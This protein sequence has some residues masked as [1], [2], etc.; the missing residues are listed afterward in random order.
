M[1]KPLPIIKPRIWPKLQLN[2]FYGG[3][4]TRDA[5]SDIADNE[6]QDLLNVDFAN[7]GGVLKRSGTNIV[8]NDKGNTKVLGLH[9]AYYG[10]GSA[11]LLMAN[12]DASTSGLWYRTTGNYTEV[13][14]DAGGTK[15]A[16]ADCEFASFYDNTNEVVFVADGTTFQKYRPSSN[17]LY[18]A[19]E[20]PGTSADNVTI[21]K[22]YKNR[23]YATGSSTNPERVY[24]SA[25]GD[26]DNFSATDYF[27]VPS[28]SVTQS[29]KTG[30]PIMA[31]TVLQNR[32]I[33]FKARSVWSYDTR[34][35][36]QLSGAHGCVGK[37]AVAVSDYFAFFA[38]NDGVY[39]LSGTSTIKVSKKIQPTWD[40]IPA[41]RIP[42]I[43]M[44]VFKG[45]LYVATAAAGAT[46][47]DII[48][49]NY[50]ELPP[51]QDGQQAW[52]YWNGLNSDLAAAAFT[53]YEASTTTIPILIFGH[54]GAQGATLQLG[55]GNADYEFTGPAQDE[56][57]D[58][59]YKTKDFPISARF[60]RLFLALGTTAAT[61]NLNVSAVI[62]FETTRHFTAGMYHATATAVTKKGYINYS[63]KYI[64]YKFATSASSAQP[65]TI[66]EGKQEFKPIR[67]R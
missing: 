2:N 58:G 45:K 60:K 34:A 1:P 5:S 65:F 44:E 38:D 26:G 36:R 17:T 48:L 43:A 32:L 7:A 61:N 3:L 27:D 6:S 59:Y 47:N 24:Y 52:S 13:T 41:A 51:D 15:L 40:V 62:D 11:H 23:L 53:V 29:G 8:G 66:Y 28:Q 35:L 9:S 19:D 18:N 12:Q 50:L 14:K 55:T 25:L 64:N 56:S 46:T 31:L 57:I 4:N 49:V 63:G 37:R 39:R 30:D 22:V 21:L 20:I 67:L 10:N 16:N 33:I 42:E 54:A